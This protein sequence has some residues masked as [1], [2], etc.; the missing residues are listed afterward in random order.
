M[1]GVSFQSLLTATAGG[2]LTTITLALSGTSPSPGNSSTIT[3]PSGILLGD[4][5]VIADAADGNTTPSAVTP[6]NFTAAVA[7]TTATGIRMC[8]SYKL[9]D[10]TEGGT[11]I[12]G[13]AGNGGGS[14]VKV[15]FVFRGNQP[16]TAVTTNSPV[17]EGTGNNPSAKNITS[18]SAIL[19]LVVIGA[20]TA[21]VG[22]GGVNP[23]AMVPAKDGELEGVGNGS[24]FDHDLWMA[25][26]IYNSSPADVAIDMEDENFNIIM[27]CYLTM[28]N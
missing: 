2:P 23:R 17:S 1:V 16:A 10:G 20:Y 5:I 11:V 15:C 6:T 26:K 13:M 24:G 7:S 4:L 14:A 19:P 22:S 3:L 9:A 25:Y 28:D 18:G 27:G 8:L 21:T 12:T